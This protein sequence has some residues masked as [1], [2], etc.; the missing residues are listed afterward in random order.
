VM[1]DSSLRVLI[2]G[3]GAAG[4]ET[5]MALHALAGDRV[6]LTLIAPD[7]EFV[8]RPLSAE[9][10][11]SVGRGRQVALSRAAR[12]ADAGFLATTV[13][14]VDPKARIARLAD[15]SVHPYDAL[16]LAIGAEAMP[17]V[18]RAVTWDDRADSELLGGLM[19]DIEQG[20][21]RSIAVLIPAGP[22]WPLRGYELA[23]LIA[24][25]AKA[26]GA[27]LKTILVTP[28]PPPLTL[29]G[30]AAVQAVS[31][32]L[33][34]AGVTVVSADH[35]QVDAGRPR[36][37]VLH[38][39]GDRHEVERVLALPVL[40]GRRVPGIPADDD[41]FVETDE[42]CRVR[43]LAAV[44]AAGDCTALP[45]KSGGFAVDQAD[46]AAQDIAALAGAPVQPT[47]FDPDRAHEIGGLP[48]GR[49]LTRWLLAGEEGLTMHLPAVGLPVLTYLRRD[50]SAGWRGYG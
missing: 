23:L 34:R 2:A 5:M 7:D 19:Q 31:E 6:D 47:S 15:G 22:G 24:L 12:D 43:D 39:S 45:L 50:L 30:G 10:P 3:G 17:A 38:P 26:M 14:A 32:E 48:A 49:F 18:D 4:L 29:L 37:V 16:V 33:D 42:H 36:A 41:G 27:E 25:D 1:G 44:W 11:F 35:A 9:P 40:R 28:Q 8:Y 13:D 20:Y 46:V 21:S